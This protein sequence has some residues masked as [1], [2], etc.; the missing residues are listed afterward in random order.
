MAYQKTRKRKLA[1]YAIGIP[2][3][4]RG[5]VLCEV[6]WQSV[7]FRNVI[8]ISITDGIA[9]AGAETPSLG[10]TVSM[11]YTGA[12]MVR[13]GYWKLFH[14]V[15]RDVAPEVYTFV[16]GGWIW[17]GDEAV[18]PWDGKQRLPHL[19]VAGRGFVDAYLHYLFCDKID[20]GQALVKIHEEM[21]PIIA[22]YLE[23]AGGEDG[24]RTNAGDRRSI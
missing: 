14:Y 20:A 6:L 19:G 16:S 8:L 12:Q 11:L 18:G 10:R 24:P 23:K 1:G 22:E 21:T 15:G 4:S 17:C 2:L 9:D 5:L 7:L 13:E 3:E